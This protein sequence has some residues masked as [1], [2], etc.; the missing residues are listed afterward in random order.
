MVD[1]VEATTE[2]VMSVKMSDG[3]TVRSTP[4]HPYYSPS[5]GHV[6][7]LDPSGTAA[8]Y[9][10]GSLE[11]RKMSPVEQVQLPSGDVVEAAVSLSA[12][13][14]T[15]VRTL[16]LDS[17]H[18][19]YT[20]ILVHNKGGFS[21][22][23]SSGSSC[24]TLDTPVVLPDDTTLP[25]GKVEAGM[26]VLSY[27]VSSATTRESVVREILSSEVSG[28]RA[29]RSAERNKGPSCQKFGSASAGR[30]R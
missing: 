16:V 30:E 17:D 4:D 7:S 15:P 12:S 23:G 8:D 1:V 18:W 2:E 29:K 5:T 27:D 22:S 20:P 11:V 6:M 21:S 9:D 19:F 14:P 26:T 13:P 28:G 3:T 24:F 10:L 25:I